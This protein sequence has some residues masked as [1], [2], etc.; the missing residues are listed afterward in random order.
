[1]NFNITGTRNGQ[2]IRVITDSMEALIADESHP[3]FNLI[4]EACVKGEDPTHLFDV[5]SAV[6]TT[7]NGL[8]DRVELDGDVITVDGEHVGRNLTNTILTVMNEGLDPIP[9]VRFL[10]NLADNPSHRSRTQLF[11]Y[12]NRHGF[13]ITDDGCFISYKGVNADGKSVS[14]GTAFVDGVKYTGRIPN[15]KGSVITMPRAQVSD[16]P[17][18]ACHQGLHAGAWGYASTFGSNDCTLK[19]KINP[20]DVVSV[21]ADF[22]QQKLRTCRYEVLE[23]T[24]KELPKKQVYY[25]EA[26]MDEAFNNGYDEGRR[27]ADPDWY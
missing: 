16:D 13:Q 25:T 8:S 14:S 27:E 24:L 18:V 23:V 12:L 26:E 17:S 4:V 21:P 6:R 1:M 5:A 3:S 9:Y 11:D 2:S 19:V 15:A 20:K 7:I 10:E 22:D